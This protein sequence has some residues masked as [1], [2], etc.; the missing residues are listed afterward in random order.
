MNREINNKSDFD[1]VLRLIGSDGQP[2]GWVD[3]NWELTLRTEGK[4]FDYRAAFA[5]GEMR[6]CRNVDGEILVAVDRHEFPVGL[7]K[8]D[9]GIDIPDDNF[10]D[11]SRHVQISGI[12]TGLEMVTDRGQ[13]AKGIVLTIN[14]PYLTKAETPEEGNTPT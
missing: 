6:N 2:L 13:A 7:L 9:F 14:V 10:P 1:F 3:A 5:Y 11:G 12:D 8:A 4:S